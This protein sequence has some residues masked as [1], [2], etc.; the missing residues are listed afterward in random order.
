VAALSSRENLTNDVAS[1]PE[2][3]SKSRSPSYRSQ[4]QFKS[5]ENY[6]NAAS[7]KIVKDLNSSS[8]A[9]VPFLDTQ[10]TSSQ[11]PF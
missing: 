3:N 8:D 6:N 4:E 1:I 5:D 2:E 11:A 10:K 7:Q 9:L